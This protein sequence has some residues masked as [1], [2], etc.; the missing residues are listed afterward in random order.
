MEEEI[1]VGIDIGTTKVCTLIARVEEDDSFRILGVGIEVS[2]GM[3]K[4]M[5]KKPRLSRHNTNKPK[6]AAVQPQTV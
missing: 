2:D 1:I 3:R 5:I 4:G 6:D